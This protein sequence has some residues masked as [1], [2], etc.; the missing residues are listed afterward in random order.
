LKKT[1]EHYVDNSAFLKALTVYA[2]AVKKAKKKQ[3]DKKDKKHLPRIPEYV[4]ECLLKIATRYAHRP[5]FMNYTFRDDMVMDGVENCLIYLHNFNP[6]KSKNPF[7]YFTTIIHYAFLRRI[8]R[9]KKQT[10]TKYKLIEQ[11]Y[12]DGGFQENAEG[13]HST[14]DT[15]LLSFDNVKEFIQQYDNHT[16][17]RRERRRQT[18]AAADAEA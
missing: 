15:T 2:E 6:K 17:K 1:S 11:A 16:E 5:N 13:S 18:K 4:G 8:L 9:E 12:I 10:Y 14:A 7:S 3:K